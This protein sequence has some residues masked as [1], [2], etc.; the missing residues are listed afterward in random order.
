MNK[1]KKIVMLIIVSAGIMACMFGTIIGIYLSTLEEGANIE[2][3]SN[4]ESNTNKGNIWDHEDVP[5]ETAVTKID[6]IVLDMNGKELESMG[7]YV[8]TSFDRYKNLYIMTLNVDGASNE[9]T[10]YNDKDRKEVREDLISSC[11]FIK[12]LFENDEYP[13]TDVCVA[14]V[15]SSKQNSNDNGIICIVLN[16]VVKYDISENGVPGKL[17]DL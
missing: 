4:L 16:G 9:Y 5:D 2:A 12:F 3:S 11:D 14:L 13:D 10:L 7:A 15:D 8:D 1:F 6:K 17:S